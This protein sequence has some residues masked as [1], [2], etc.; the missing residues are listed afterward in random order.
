MRK[1][2][3]QLHGCRLKRFNLSTCKRIELCRITTHK[4]REYRTGNHCILSLQPFNQPRHIFGSKAQAMHTR[5]QFYM[6]REV[7]DSFLLRLFNQCIQQVEA[8]H[9]RLQLIVEHG[10]E[11]GHLRVHDDDACRDTRFAEFGTFISHSHSQE[12]NMMFLQGLGNLIRTGPI[13]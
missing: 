4:V 9:F 3:L 8:I 6:N 11:R 5:I 1:C 2:F 13:G 7:S 10:L 12:I